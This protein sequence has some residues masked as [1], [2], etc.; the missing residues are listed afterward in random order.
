MGSAAR[1]VL[2]EA[3]LWGAVAL[4]GFALIYFFDD[5]R[6]ALDPNALIAQREAEAPAEP[7]GMRQSFGGEVRLGIALPTSGPAVTRTM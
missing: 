6:V 3:L 1:H 2:H 5:L 7:R 4:G